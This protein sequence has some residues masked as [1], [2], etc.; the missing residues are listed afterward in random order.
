MR[1]QQSA[2]H[3]IVTIP[4]TYRVIV[5]GSYRASPSGEREVWSSW[6]RFDWG[7]QFSAIH[8]AST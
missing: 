2:K 6:K 1:S 8:A 5:F 4:H 7:L 3:G